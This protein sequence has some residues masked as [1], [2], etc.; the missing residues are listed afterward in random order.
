MAY[1]L[2]YMGNGGV[3]RLN[4]HF[5]ECWYVEKVIKSPLGVGQDHIWHGKAEWNRGRDQR[6]I[7]SEESLSTACWL[8]W[9]SVKRP[10]SSAC[11]PL[12]VFPAQ[13]WATH[14]FFLRLWVMSCCFWGLAGNNL[15][16]WGREKFP[17]LVTHYI[18]P[19]IKRQFSGP[20]HQPQ[21]PSMCSSDSEGLT[22]LFLSPWIFPSSQQDP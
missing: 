9:Q 13:A 5:L 22:K 12:P 21:C 19:K 4:C 8:P 11:P 16:S 20:D 6:G 1:F 14:N 18:I 15:I 10:N 3:T 17:V 7:A 2:L